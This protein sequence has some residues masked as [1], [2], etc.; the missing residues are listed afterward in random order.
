M[1]QQ[2]QVSTLQER[3]RVLCGLEP[4]TANTL[5]T[6]AII[7]DLVR[8]AL[9]Q[10]GGIIKEYSDQQLLTTFGL[11]ATT[12]G[13]SVVSLPTGF[14]DLMRISW[15]RTATE[16]TPLEW[17]DVDN[18]LASPVA[19]S[20]SW[21]TFTVPKYRVMGANTVELYP[22][23][24]AAYNLKLHYTTGIYVTTASDFVV[25]Q[26]S[27]DQWVV[28]YTCIMVR[29]AQQKEGEAVSPASFIALLEK[30][31]AAIRKRLKKSRDK[32]GIETIR[33][34]RGGMVDANQLFGGKRYWRG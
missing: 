29:L 25:M 7:L 21:D 18:W 1:S 28:F 23:P 5:F 12:P 11:V 33:D 3:V 22:T 34:V 30:E 4:Y 2:V 9:T 14:S 32:F 20:S 10:L 16:E 24:Q 13:L 15:L 27:W 31:D 8:A 17:A 26:D 19:S 6:P